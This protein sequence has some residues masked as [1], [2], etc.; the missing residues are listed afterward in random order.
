MYSA[1]LQ[2]FICIFWTLYTGKELK[3]LIYAMAKR[4]YRV[5]N[6]VD[7]KSR[8]FWQS[9]KERSAKYGDKAFYPG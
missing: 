1:L 6:L 5:F 3:H 9:N 4:I 8:G 2:I 7:I